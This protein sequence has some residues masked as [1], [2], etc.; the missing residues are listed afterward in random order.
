LKNILVIEDEYDLIS[1]LGMVLTMEEYQ[2][3]RAFNGKEALELLK[4]APEPDLIISDLMM[5]IMNGYEFLKTFR[6]NV[7]NKNIPVILVSA[8]ALDETRLEPKSF[9]LFVRKPYD[10]ELLLDAVARLLS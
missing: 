6:A 4:T 3:R 10:L 2:V 5:P 7:A 8:A 9:N 1:S